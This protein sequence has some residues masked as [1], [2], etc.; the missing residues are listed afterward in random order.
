MFFFKDW[1]RSRVGRGGRRSTGSGRRRRRAR[2]RT[3]RA[4][5]WTARRKPVVEATTE[6]NSVKLGKTLGEPMRL[7]L[8]AFES[9]KKQTKAKQ[10]LGKTR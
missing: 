7:T 3:A 5:R 6:K 10:K 2:R 1:V 8:K 4:P 9:K